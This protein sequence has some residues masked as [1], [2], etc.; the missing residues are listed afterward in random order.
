M[1]ILHFFIVIE[2]LKAGFRRGKRTL[3]LLN[4]NLRVLLLTLSARFKKIA[5][6]KNQA[7]D[8]SKI[9][10][11]LAANCTRIKNCYIVFVVHKIM[12]YYGISIYQYNSG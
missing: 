7:Q 12:Q 5:A 2:V 11:T 9:N 6:E 8:E 4:E 3:M 10:M 1:F